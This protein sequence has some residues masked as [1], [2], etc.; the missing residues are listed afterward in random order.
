[1]DV[2]LSLANLL[3]IAPPLVV[4][5]AALGVILADLW[6]RD[7]R[8]LAFLG[9]VG[10]VAAAVVGL[11]FRG[12]VGDAALDFQ[13]MARLDSL[14][15]VLD[16][17]LAVVAGLA[18]LISLDYLDRKAVHYGEYYALLL[19]ATAGMMWM[20]GATDL[21][22]VFL[23]L[24]IF[25]IALYVLV[26]FT[27]EEVR[28]LE[29]ALKYFLLGAFASGFFLYGI[30][31]TYAATGTTRLERVVAFLSQS[32]GP[33]PILLLA[34][35]M[36]L[37]GF[38]FKLAL[39]PFHMWAPDA[40]QGAP[41][42]VTAFMSVG[43]KAAGFGALARVLLY[44]F[45]GLQTYW[46]W[47]VAVLALLTM[48]LG[49]LAA[50]AQGSLKRMLAYSS[51]A[52]AGYILVGVAAGGDGLGGVLFYLMAYALMNVGAFAVVLALEGREDLDL[53]LEAVAGLGRRHPW[54]T[55]AMTIFLLSLTGMPPLAGFLGK[56]YVF[57]AAVKNGLLW[58]AIAGV[59]NAV[60]SAFYY[61][62]V[63]LVMAFRPL[64]GE[65]H[66][67][68]CPALRTALVLSAVGTV[69]LGLWPSP[70]LQMAVHAADL[71]LKR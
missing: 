60:V 28:S 42:S 52:H 37:V 49:N 65:R 59:L 48:T 11:A 15:V 25:S 55:A 14:A 18:L 5:L 46:V 3:A 54:L 2:T 51:I 62:R 68:S 58:L 36:L 19:L 13:G 40:Y 31:L 10:V 7:K 4:L 21:L 34:G 67:A 20:A 66:P 35:G 63:V 33:A 22:V 47:P 6:V 30:A 64:E 16:L 24:E 43:V 29:G 1:M 61:L 27:R 44:A 32:G 56:L 50:L 12:S 9:L 70:L 26:A 45:P 39:V 71:F 17:V 53:T 8:W 41:T 23:G 57:S 69:I 38:A